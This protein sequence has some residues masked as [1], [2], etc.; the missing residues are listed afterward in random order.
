MADATILDTILE[1]KHS[2]VAERKAKVPLTELHARL[3]DAPPAR[4]FANALRNPRTP[5]TAGAS[6]VAL[7]AEVKKASPSAGIIRAD[8]EPVTIAR[9]YEENGAMCLSV[10][11]DERFFQGHDEYLKAVH[12]SVSLPIIRKDFTVDH[13]QIYETRALGADAI[14]LI[15]AALTP[16]QVRDYLQIATSIG[17]D[18]LVEV[19]TEDEMRIAIDSGATLIGVNTRDLKRFVTDLATFERLAPMAPADS[20]LVAE[21]G[22]KS[23]ADVARVKSAGAHAILVG[24]SLMRQPDIAV[25]VREL[26]G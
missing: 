22:I 1:Q 14:L 26:L 11:T 24:E 17:L 19:H 8:F 15:V 6:G 3:P 4:G 12:E 25:A 5:S 9:T 16:D 21:S 18:A 13:Y 10:L 20:T 2:E 23:P 7:I